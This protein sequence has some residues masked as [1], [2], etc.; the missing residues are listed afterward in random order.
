MKGSLLV[1]NVK[2]HEPFHVIAVS[3]VIHDH[4]QNMVIRFY[5]GGENGRILLNLSKADKFPVI[6]GLILHLSLNLKNPFYEGNLQGVADA[7]PHVEC[8]SDKLI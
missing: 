1:G 4:R 6:V 8:I 2:D 7:V 5:I 3:K